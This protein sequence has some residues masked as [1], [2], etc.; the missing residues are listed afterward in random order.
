MALFDNFDSIPIW[1]LLALGIGA[2]V[3]VFILMGVYRKLK[4]KMRPDGS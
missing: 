2:I 3:A 4:E 1:F